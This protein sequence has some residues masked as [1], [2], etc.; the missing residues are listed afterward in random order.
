MTRHDTSARCE[1][2]DG[3]CPSFSILPYG[4]HLPRTCM[5]GGGSGE[6]HIIYHT[7]EGGDEIT[8]GESILG[9][10][11]ILPFFC[12]KRLKSF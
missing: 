11:M 3:T 7:I 4:C 8:R 2:Q 9:G 5:L 12:G 10:M 1:V 6:Y